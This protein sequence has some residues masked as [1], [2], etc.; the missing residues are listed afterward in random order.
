MAGFEGVVV[1]DEPNGAARVPKNVV[2]VRRHAN[3][4]ELST[5][6][7]GAVAF[8]GSHSGHHFAPLAP[9]LGDGSKTVRRSS[10]GSA[11]FEVHRE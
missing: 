4:Q 2:L 11:V 8:M 6:I 9:A 10:E 5:P 7:W 3:Q 1:E